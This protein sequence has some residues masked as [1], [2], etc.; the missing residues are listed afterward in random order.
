MIDVVVD[1]YLFSNMLL[2]AFRT[3]QLPIRLYLDRWSYTERPADGHC[4]TNRVYVYG[5]K[6]CF[7]LSFLEATQRN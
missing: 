3:H 4:F 1:L 6:H 5:R 2:I 7:H